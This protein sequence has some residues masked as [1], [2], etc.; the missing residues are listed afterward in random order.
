MGLTVVLNLYPKVKG[1]TRGKN[2]LVL[3]SKGKH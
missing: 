3:G 1:Q 2:I